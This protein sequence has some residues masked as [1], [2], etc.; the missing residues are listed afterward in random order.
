MTLEVIPP[1][2]SDFGDAALLSSGDAHLLI[3]TYLASE[4]SNVL[5]F[6]E[7]RGIKTLDIY[8]SHY[9]SD[10][11]G[12][13]ECIIRDKRFKVRYLYL[14]EVSYLANYGGVY[15]TARTL[16]EDYKRIMRV[17]KTYKTDVI[18]LKEGSTFKVGKV[19]A[20]VLFGPAFTRCYSDF[21]FNNY[22]NNNSLVTRFE[23]KGVRYLTCG[24]LSRDGETMLLRSVKDLKAD[25][26][27]LNHHGRRVSEAFMRK[28]D[29]TYAYYQFGKES[30]FNTDPDIRGTLGSAMAVS[31]V[32]SSSYNRKIVFKVTKKG[33]L[34]V[35]V[36]RH[37]YKTNKRSKLHNGRMILITAN[38]AQGKIVVK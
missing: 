16:L 4:R 24:D 7:K 30:V 34:Q 18:Y 27:K 25:I 33:G 23:C 5:T 19:E 26:L 13:I 17:A 20:E 9:H 35:T 37:A 31:N 12:N 21:A 1:T 6:L 11:Y 2:N 8:L 22:V 10:H 32:F 15:E 28:V 3:D 38:R 29:P 14:P 36:Q